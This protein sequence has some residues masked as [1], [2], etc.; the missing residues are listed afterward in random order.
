MHRHYHSIN[1]NEYRT[2]W[3]HD[4]L[5]LEPMVTAHTYEN[6]IKASNSVF[7]FQDVD[8]KKFG[9]FDYP[10]ITGYYNQ[11]SILG[12]GGVTQPVANQLLNKLN[13]QIGATKQV[14]MFILVFRNQPVE[15]GFEQE[16]YWKGGNKNEFIITLG[17]NDQDEI[18]W[19]H[20]FSWTEVEL[21]KIQIRDFVTEQKTL[22]LEKLVQGVVPQIQ[23]SF[24]RKHFK[25]FNYLTVEPPTWAIL[26]TFLIT[27][28]VNLGVAY[29][30]VNN[31]YGDFSDRFK[32]SFRSRMYS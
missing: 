21:L 22:N 9:L 29:W 24:K 10:K 3:T 15:A 28:A 30:V 17:V 13:A 25:D 23:A 26:L 4:D 8:P 14:R 12:N 32:F 2:T 11:A 20:P 19:C 16:C 5:R 7:K 18:Q 6:R 1:G 31:D 27:I